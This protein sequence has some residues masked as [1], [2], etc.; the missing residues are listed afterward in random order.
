M[1]IY[2]DPGD[3]YRKRAVK[4]LT[5]RLLT[6]F[7]LFL[8]FGFAFWLGGLSAQKNIFQLQQEKRAFEQQLHEM[9]SEMTRIRAEAQ[10][11]NIRLE[12]MR[13]SFDEALPEGPMQKL[14]AL[15]R[16]QL[17][18][19]IDEKR[20]ES[21]IIAARPPQNCS[22]PENRNFVIMT[23]KYDGP[24]SELSID[25]GAVIVTGAGESAVND[26]N[27]QQSWFDPGKAVE[28]TFTT[29]DGKTDVKKGVLPLQHVM[30]AKGRE[31]R[32]SVASGAQSFAQVTF[33]SCDY[34]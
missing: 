6:L 22:R 7:F 14:V 1:S 24:K 27:Q 10:T 26:R 28:V 18:N 30:I 21:V 12:Q 15:L 11:S 33:D 13:T 3:R 25:S 4:K 29:A 34:P 8:T 19:G 23:P 17:D 2:Y 32:F 16:K 5:G 9:Q 31:Y 20:L